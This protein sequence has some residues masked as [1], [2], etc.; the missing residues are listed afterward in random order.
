MSYGLYFGKNLTESS[1]AYL[2]GYGDEPSRRAVI[3]LLPR[4]FIP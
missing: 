2:G 3:K 4:I 1:I